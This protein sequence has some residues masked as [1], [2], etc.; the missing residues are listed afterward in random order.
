MESPKAVL[1]E[2]KIIE[3]SLGGKWALHTIERSRKVT[4]ELVLSFSSVRWVVQTQEVF[5]CRSQQ[6]VH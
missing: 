1:I 4:K 6:G 5:S 3:I 2:T